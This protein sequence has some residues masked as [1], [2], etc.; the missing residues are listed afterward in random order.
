MELR[1][2]GN[3]ITNLKNSGWMSAINVA[4]N[5]AYKKYRHPLDLNVVHKDLGKKKKQA[6]QT[7][8]HTHTHDRNYSFLIGEMLGV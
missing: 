6:K 3:R 1:G 8:T 5:V 2:Y 4:K 7:H